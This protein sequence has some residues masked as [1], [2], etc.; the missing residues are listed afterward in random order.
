MKLA[1]SPLEEA[2]RRLNSRMVS[3]VQK[4]FRTGGT[5]GVTIQMVPDQPAL[6]RSAPKAPM[7]P[8]NP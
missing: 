3:P 6:S 1:A 7:A 8:S 5:K 4:G 2:L